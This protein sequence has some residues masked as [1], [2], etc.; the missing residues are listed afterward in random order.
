M[1]AEPWP[2]WLVLEVDAALEA[3]ADPSERALGIQRVLTKYIPASLGAMTPEAEARAWSALD[4]YL[5]AR[6]AP[7]KRWHLTAAQSAEAVARI[8]E[9]AARLR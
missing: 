6:P 3:I 1:T 2:D 5:T 9:I 7:R 8:K 4:H